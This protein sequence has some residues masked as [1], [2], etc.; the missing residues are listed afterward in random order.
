MATSIKKKLY[1]S[2]TIPATQN[3]A[4]YSAL[5]WTQVKGMVSIG[6]VGFPHETIPV[7]DLE[8]GIT[9]TFKGAR[10]G[11]GAQ[12]AWRKIAADAGQTALVAANEGETEVAIQIVNPD[13]TTAEFWT[14]II[15]SLTSNEASTTSYEGSTCT[16]V[17]NY[18]VVTGAA[19]V[20]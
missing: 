12:L 16:F 13:G 19:D 15:H 20:S 2:A 5:S 6:S 14:G 9:K 11:S 17:P 7:P 18:A 3:L 1:V 8:T 10:A 4:G